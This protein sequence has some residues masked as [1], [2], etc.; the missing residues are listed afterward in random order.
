MKAILP[1]LRY[2]L[3]PYEGEL[4]E[5]RKSYVELGE[6]AVPILREGLEMWRGDYYGHAKIREE[7][8]WA[9][10]ELGSRPTTEELKTLLNDE[11]VSTSH[12]QNKE[13][14]VTPCPYCGK[15]LRTPL[16]QQC[17]ECHKDWHGGS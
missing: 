6:K 13:K 17:F 1:T 8:I 14:E 12:N 7:I 9:L 5:V 3:V 4:H 10:E 11:T 16:A 15:P 2:V